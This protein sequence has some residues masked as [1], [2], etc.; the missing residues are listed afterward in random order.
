[1]DTTVEIVYAYFNEESEIN[2]FIRKKAIQLYQK[3]LLRKYSAKFRTCFPTGSNCIPFLPIVY[4]HRDRS[5]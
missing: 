2:I 4:L 5:P 1:M 3:L